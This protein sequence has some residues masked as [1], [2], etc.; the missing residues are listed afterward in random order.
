MAS[1]FSYA[2]G[3]KMRKSILKLILISLAVFLPSLSFADGANVYYDKGTH[4]ELDGFNLTF[5]T[6]LQPRYT[7]TDTDAGSRSELGFSDSDKSS[8]EMHLARLI[9]SGELTDYN[10]SY[11]LEYDLHDEEKASSDSSELK[12]AWIQWNGDPAKIRFGQFKQPFGREERIARSRLFFIDRTRT[13]DTFTFV[14]SQGAMVTADVIDGTLIQAAVFN[15][16]GTEEGINESGADTKMQGVVG[17]NFTSADFGSRFEQ[18]DFRETDSFAW[19]FG[20]AVSYGE[21][22]RALEGD[23]DKLDINADIGIRA[24]GF[25]FSGEYFHSDVELEDTTIAGEDNPK[26]NGFTVAATYTCSTN[27]GV[28][29][30]FG[31]IDPDNAIETATDVSGVEEHTVVLNYFLNG[32]Y[33]KLQTGVS[34]RQTDLNTTSDLD[35]FRYD[36]QL[37]GYF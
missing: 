16:E 2:K 35:D 17:F 24:S 32:H 36:L 25:E 10:L 22:T 28:G 27:F 1:G 18:G 8:F 30:R 29:Y 15:G 7:Y 23:F 4:L 26:D 31:L 11:G 6:L 33:L 14:R 21:G 12:D 13:S 19:T 3:E 20:S 5:N 34:Y 37:S 9:I